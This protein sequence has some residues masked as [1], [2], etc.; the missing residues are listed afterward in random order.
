MVSRSNSTIHFHF[1]TRHFLFSHRNKLKEFLNRLFKREGKDIE[2]INYIFCTDAYL[3]ELNKIHLHHNTYTDILTFELSP[4]G[5]PLT[6]DIYI[7]VER[8]KENAATFDTTFQKE[9]H[10]V[11]FHGALHLCGYKD[12]SDEQSL[13]M[14]SMEEHYLN[15]YFVPRGTNR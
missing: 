10:R 14:R 11:I 6:A 12:K 8:V 2:A 13:Q 15:Q 1:L 5:K 9:L 4:K 3:L 7:S